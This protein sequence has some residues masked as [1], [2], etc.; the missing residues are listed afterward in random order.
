MRFAVTGSTGLIGSAL[1]ADLRAA[2][3]SVTRLV[4]SPDTRSSAERLIHWNP[5][6]GLLEAA[7]LENHDAVVHFAGESLIGLWTENKKA[8]IR[9]SR[10]RGTSLLARTLATLHHP[11]AV[12]VSASAVGYYG[13][14]A[15]NDLVDEQTPKG[16]GFLADVVEAWEGATAPAQAAGIRVATTRFGLVLSPRGGALAVMLPIFQAGLGGKVGSGDQVWSWVTLPEVVGAIS[17]VISQTEV[18]GPV[19][20]TAPKAVTNREFTHVL[21]KVLNR[22]TVFTA[23]AFALRLALRG[24]ADEMLLSG[25]RVIP[26]KLQQSGYEF[27]HPELEGALR[28]M[29][30][31]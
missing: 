22:P 23:P 29:L 27:R 19:N 17:H 8:R 28:A 26:R 14:H 1:V 9:E 31:R 7:P 16:S 21:G 5:E 10:I 30:G 15:G 20:V 2:G 4:R 18:Q 13:N 25:A 11:P 24:M 6:R 3:H 12:F